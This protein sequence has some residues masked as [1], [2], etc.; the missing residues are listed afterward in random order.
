[1][2]QRFLAGL[3]I[4]QQKL[5]HFVMPSTKRKLDLVPSAGSS[6]KV[7]AAAQKVAAVHEGAPC[8]PVESPLSLPALGFCYWI[9]LGH[10]AN[11]WGLLDS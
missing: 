7:A 10:C 5:L 1:M 9:L 11:M 4:C 8:L 3:F 2:S 6:P